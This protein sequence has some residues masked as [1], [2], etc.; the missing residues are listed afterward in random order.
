MT[1]SKALQTGQKRLPR[2][3]FLDRDGTISVDIPYCS[4]VEDFQLLPDAPRAI[5]SLATHG[6][7]IVIVTNQSGIARG[8][9][10]HTTL[11]DI[12]DRMQSFVASCGGRVDA[13]YSCPHHPEDRCLC[14]KPLPGLLLEASSNLG[15]DLE[16]SYLIGDKETDIQAARAA[17]CRAIL[18]ASPPTGSTERKNIRDDE[19]DADFGARDLIEA[20][21]WILQTEQEAAES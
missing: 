12:H 10:N 6:F 2:A 14:R 4:R 7:L 3:I 18:V 8:Y 1:V 20:T 16:H 19:S 15:I 5:A 21:K 9:L 11:K 13:I 17:G